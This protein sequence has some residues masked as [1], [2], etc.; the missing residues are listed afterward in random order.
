M[1]YFEEIYYDL[2]F[3]KRNLFNSW[4]Q[5]LVDPSYKVMYLYRKG[6]YFSNSKFRLLRIYSSILRNKLIF[7]R[8]SEISFK[9][10]IGKNFRL[11]HPVSIVIGTG[12][13]IKDNVKVFQN[14]TLGSHGS[15][16]TKLKSYP[17]IENN[18]TIYAGAVII[19]GIN[20][21]ENSIIGA[22]TLVNIDVPPNSI[23]IGNPCKI[24]M[25]K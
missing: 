20:I 17:I 15:S 12:V 2:P 22:N 18:V 7:K 4:K 9:A 21:G 23:A 1:K 16:K 14:V 10:E 19:G 13:V 5:R 25:K 24:I 3:N 6:K 11:A 8:N